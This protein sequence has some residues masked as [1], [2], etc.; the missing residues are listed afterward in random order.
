MLYDIMKVSIGFSGPAGSGVN[1][2]GIFL[3]E[4]L[5]ARGY[6]VMGDK[7]YASIIKGDN[8]CFF[9][10]ISDEEEV[11]IRKQIDFFLAYD[12]YAVSKNEP[13]YDLKNV[14]MI[15]EEKCKYKNTFTLGAALRLLNLPLEE[16][17][18]ILTRQFAHKSFAQEVMDQNFAD[19]EAGY[20]YAGEHCKDS[21][22][23]INCD[24]QL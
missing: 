4:I 8:N 3:A 12:P 11:F 21:C 14:F 10:Y 24:K 19:L 22:A 16:G 23:I 6:T 2:A 5:A 15:K 9:L 1:T 7:E 18:T 13:I 20:N 17:K